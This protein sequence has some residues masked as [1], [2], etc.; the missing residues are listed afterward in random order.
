MTSGSTGSLPRATPGRPWVSRLTH[1]I[2]AGSSGS[3]RPSERAGEHD[4]D[5]GGAAGQAVEQEPADVGVDPAAL[6]GGGH[7]GGQVVV[8]EDEVGGLAGD[9]GA[10]FAHGHADVGAVQGRAVVDAVAGHR[11]DVAA[12][13][14]GPG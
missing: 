12:R 3:G 9:L 10:A 5:L 2:W 1:R 7:D 6:L 4:E 8:G 13:R 11:D 14:G